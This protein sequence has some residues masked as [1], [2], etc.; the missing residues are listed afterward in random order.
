[1]ISNGRCLAAAILLIGGCHDQST[2][3]EDLPSDGRPIVLAQDY[4]HSFYGV[5][6]LP[7]NAIVDGTRAQ[8]HLSQ[9]NRN[10]VRIYSAAPGLVLK[11]G[12]VLGQISQTLD[13]RDIYALGDS[14]AVKVRDALHV[15][16]SG[17]RIDQAWDGI[18]VDQG[19]DGW[20]IENVHISNN[21]D[22]AVENDQILSGTIR[23]SLIDGT[24]SGV[25]MDSR[26]DR[27]G[28]M[29]MVRLERVL[30]RLK[31]YLVDG[32][33]THGG[34]IKGE[35]DIP[36]HNPKL[37]FI[38]CVIA[39]ERTDHSMMTRTREAWKNTLEARG[40][41]FLNLSDTPLPDNYPLPPAGFTV[42]QG[43]AARDHWQA[44][45]HAWLATR[46]R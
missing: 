18:R 42:L 38:D 15:K 43:Q 13:W 10:P 46:T 14:A 17:W 36:G 12:A 4:G 16:I 22:D 29:N 5:K 8:W 19:T 40:S 32:K 39:I 2:R 21:R 37:R 11:G 30:I 41:Y 28:S 20:L 33:V 27:D 26:D 7:A 34:P 3:A 31:P 6:N 25:S 24:Y 44:A 35:D 1:M 9:A 23:D 45:K